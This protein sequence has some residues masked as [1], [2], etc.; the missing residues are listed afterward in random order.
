MVEFAS[1]AKQLFWDEQTESFVKSSE[2]VPSQENMIFVTEDDLVS[3]D[4]LIMLSYSPSL[5]KTPKPDF[6]SRKTC[7]F[8]RSPYYNIS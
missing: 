4:S 5:L 6:Q 7:Q 2:V 1:E 3:D 8:H